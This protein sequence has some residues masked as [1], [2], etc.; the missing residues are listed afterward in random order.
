MGEGIALHGPK[1]EHEAALGVEVLAFG[2]D[3]DLLGVVG[4]H[5]LGHAL[6]V[7]EVGGGHA[8]PA[9]GRVG[10]GGSLGRAPGRVHWR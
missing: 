3:G 9:C 5:A 6:D 2:E 1:F 7:G 4:M 10:H 8:A